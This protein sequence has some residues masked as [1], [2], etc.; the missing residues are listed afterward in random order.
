MPVPEIGAALYGPPTLL[1]GPGAWDIGVDL[2]GPPG[3]DVA[4][5]ARV[6]AAAL[7]ELH[8]FAARAP[9]EQGRAALIGLDGATPASCNGLLRLLEVPGAM[10]LVLAATH[11]T[12]V[13]IRSR[14]Q[15][16]RCSGAME[17][18][19]L[20][21]NI[22]I[23]RS[24]ALNALKAVAMK[25][26]DLLEKAA[27]AADETVIRLLEIWAYEAITRRWQIFSESESFGLTSDP[28]FARRMLMWM[29]ELISP[30]LMIKTMFEK[31]MSA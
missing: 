21:D 27:S 13:T 11:M 4:H 16:I 26:R 1:L 7:A 6:D 17:E 23:P 24:I 19:G 5:Y 18:S 28:N 29:N 14:V 10:R 9:H 8:R 31:V 22:D 15:V 20:P 30:R 3:P 12:M 25:N 2:L